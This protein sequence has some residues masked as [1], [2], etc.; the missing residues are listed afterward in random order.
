MHSMF[1]IVGGKL[2]FSFRYQNTRVVLSLR[3]RPCCRYLMH[4]EEPREY[5]NK[6][7]RGLCVLGSMCGLELSVVMASGLE[8]T[9]RSVI[10]EG[11][12][13]KIGETYEPATIR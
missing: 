3:C 1:P 6:W 5:T 8:D 7:P 10:H 12:L 4:V 9:A 11:G 13:V 2:Q